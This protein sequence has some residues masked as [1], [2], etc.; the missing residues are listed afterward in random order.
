MIQIPLQPL[1]NQS[2]FITLDNNQWNF[3]LK[4]TNGVISA[5]IS[6]NGVEILS[7]TRCV[8]NQLIIPSIYEESGNFL[9]QTQLFQLP[10]YTQIGITQRLVY[11]TASELEIYRTPVAF[12][13]TAQDFNPIA[14]LPLRFTGSLGVYSYVTTDGGSMITTDDGSEI[15]LGV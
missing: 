7:N 4:T 13:I 15:I 8:A 6:L 1:P 9:F 3:T 11:V 12:P 14:A 2:F 10:E 5:S